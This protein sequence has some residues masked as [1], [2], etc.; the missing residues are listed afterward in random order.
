[1]MWFGKTP[2]RDTGKSSEGLVCDMV[3]STGY[4]GSQTC[5]WIQLC[6]CGKSPYLSKSSSPSTQKSRQYVRHLTVVEAP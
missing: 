6:D 2:G 3:M 5:V 1:M 4:R